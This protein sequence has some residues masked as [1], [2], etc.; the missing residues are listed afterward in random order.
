MCDDDD[1]Y[2]YVDWM[3]SEMELEDSDS[4]SKNDDKKGE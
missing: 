2:E 1:F 4:E 3:E